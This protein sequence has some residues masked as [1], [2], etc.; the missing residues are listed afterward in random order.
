MPVLRLHFVYFFILHY[1][2]SS[3]F[4]IVNNIER[5]TWAEWFKRKFSGK[6]KKDDNLDLQIALDEI[7]Q[8]R[9]QN[10]MYR[11]EIRSLR[12]KLQNRSFSQR[13]GSLFKFL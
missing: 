13:K 9:A 12:N 1:I 7:E 3:N 11:D 6:K 5:E 2:C 4:I 10:D 8:L